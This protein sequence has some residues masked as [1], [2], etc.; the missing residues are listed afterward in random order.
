MKAMGVNE[1]RILIP[2]AGIE[3]IQG[4]DYYATTDYVVNAANQRGMAILGV[5]NSTPSWA[6]PA[7]SPIYSTPPTSDAAFASF[8]AAVATRYAGQISAYEV[9]NEPNSYGFWSPTPSAADYTKLLQAAYP[10]I[11]AADPNA[12]VIAAGL[13]SLVN[14]GNL[15]INPIDYLTQMYQAGAKGYFDAVAIHP[16]QFTVYFSQG[17]PYG[18]AAP[19]NQVAAMHTVMVANGDG[20][21]LI[22]STEYGEPTSVVYGISDA[23]QASM[24]QD[25]LTSWSQLSYAGPSFIYTTVDVN[26]ASTDPNYTFGVV[27]SDWTWKPAA[28]TIQQWIAAHPQQPVTAQVMTAL[29]LATRSAVLA[30][31]S[32]SNNATGCEVADSVQ[33]TCTVQ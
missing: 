19:I 18:D 15:A 29:A 30:A 12:T 32:S 16:Y 9:W 6:I 5:L 17:G 33:N 10:A 4:A 31:N 24:I 26:S 28:Y 21:K 2:W 7:G 23:T 20:N 14:N 27:R 13:I 8:A 25:Y 22:W 1:V 11:K 3:P